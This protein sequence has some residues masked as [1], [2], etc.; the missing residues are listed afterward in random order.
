MAYHLASSS[1]MSPGKALVY[2]RI[3]FAPMYPASLLKYYIC[4]RSLCMW[5]CVCLSAGAPAVCFLLLTLFAIKINYVSLMCHCVIL[6]ISE[7]YLMSCEFCSTQQQI[8]FP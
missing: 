7:F 8:S 1:V 5:W 6:G 2:D 3:F 4:T